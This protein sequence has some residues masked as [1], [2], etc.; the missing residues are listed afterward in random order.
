MLFLKEAT[1]QL[2]RKFLAAWYKESAGIPIII[3]PLR[4][5][6]LP[7]P[8]ALENLGFVFGQYEPHVVREITS[9]PGA[10]KI[11][12]DVGAHIGFMSL[13]LLKRVGTMGKVFAFEPVP[14][15]LAFIEQLISL[16]SLDRLIQVAPFAVGD[17]NGRQKMVLWQSPSMFLLEDAL[18]G[19]KADFSPRIEIEGCSLDAF[20]FERENPPPDMIKVDVEGAEMQVLRGAQRTLE[21]YSP[22]M[23][24]EIHGPKCAYETWDLVQGLDYSWWH[25]TVREREVVFSKEKLLSYFSKDSWT[26]HFLLIKD[27]HLF[28]A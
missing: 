6:R 10:I 1:K 19:Q 26:H 8:V 18:N 28:K 16:N 24:M 20:V 13:A 3:G 27:R 7:K 25:L 14:E 15:N 4:G 2:A 9:A 5:K 21:I 12:Y 17:N 11:A 23:I 22:A